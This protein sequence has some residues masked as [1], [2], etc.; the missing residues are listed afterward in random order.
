LTRR[1]AFNETAPFRTRPGFDMKSTCY[2][3]VA[4]ALVPLAARAQPAAPSVESALRELAAPV[5][6]VA[7]I[8]D[9]YHAP[10]DVGSGF[11][12][13][14]SDLRNGCEDALEA[15][16]KTNEPVDARLLKIAHESK[17]LRE[18][19]RAV[20]VLVQHKNANAIPVLEKMTRSTDPEERYLAWCAYAQGVSAKN[21]A[22][23]R[24]FDAALK[25]C[26][27]EPNRYVRA[28]NMGFFG[29]CKAKEAVPHLVA[30][31]DT[32]DSE[33]AVST[34]GD[35]R[36]PDSVPAII[37]RLK[38][39]SPKSFAG[40]RHVY[41]RALGNIGSADAV[42]CLIECIDEG[43]FAVEALFET[44]SPKALPAIEKYLARLKRETD[45]DDLDLAV[46]QVCTLRL[47]HADPRE[48]LLALAEDR[49]QSRWMRSRALR[50]LMEY[51]RAPLVPRLLKLYKAEADDAERTIYI[52][53]LCD[54]P[55]DDIT[56]ALIDHALADTKNPWFLTQ[57]ELRDALNE[58]LN[59]SF[60]EMEPLVL[61]LK[62]LRAEKIK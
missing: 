39:I 44:R 5:K 24:S 53:L 22:A 50:A 4:V 61:H 32:R 13:R 46:A 52:R 3:L 20:W 54:V 36:D 47:K 40:N 23:P 17:E 31:L 25:Q 41:F 48:H 60:R 45:P 38:K 10:G 2:A 15:L 6:P 1:G 58:R 35:I 33:T 49:K 28:V 51:D 7:R 16:A 11:V 9:L 43:C 19:Y 42:D 12:W 26:K 62:K 8:N 30:A 55:G 14:Q 27:D 18:R 37:K 56:E 57:G 59:T 29:T 21:I 34:L